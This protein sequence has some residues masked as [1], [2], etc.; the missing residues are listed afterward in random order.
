MTTPESP[1]P[2]PQLDAPTPAPGPSP[3]PWKKRF[4]RGLLIAILS[5]IV[6]LALYTV[7]MYNW[8]Y[9]QGERSGILR[10]FSKKGWICKTWEG[11]LAMTTVPGVMPELWAFTVRDD[12]VARAVTAALG[13]EVV[14]HYSEHRGLWSDCFGETSYFIDSVRVIGEP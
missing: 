3:R 2:E 4:K 9:S 12:S 11:E 6:A 5:P 13:E 7:V 1:D 8:A 14:L 10:K